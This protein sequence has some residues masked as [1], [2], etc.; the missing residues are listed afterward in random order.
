M[1]SYGNGLF[2]PDGGPAP[3]LQYHRWASRVLG[4]ASCVQIHERTPENDRLPRSGSTVAR[5]PTLT[6]TRT[7]NVMRIIWQHLDMEH[8]LDSY[9]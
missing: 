5:L 2:G 1:L 6:C 7:A 4:G 8:E 3:S 9:I